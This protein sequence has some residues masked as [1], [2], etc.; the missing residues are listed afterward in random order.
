MHPGSAAAAPHRAPGRSCAGSRAARPRL[1][2]QPRELR[3]RVTPQPHRQRDHVGGAAPFQPVQE[4]QPPLRIRQWDLVRPRQRHQRRPRRL[5]FAHALRQALDGRRLE[6]AADRKLH[7]QGRADPADQPRR[8]Q[9]VAAEREEVVVDPDTLE[10]QHLRKQR[11]QHLLA[12]RARTA[13]APR[14]SDRAPAAH[15][16]RACRS[17]SAAAVPAPHRPKAPCS[18]AGSPPHA[19]AAQTHRA[20]ARRA[21][22]T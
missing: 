11:A 9:R 19:P 3:G 18:P 1:P 8:Q 14:G 22:T 16:G 20:S 5:A 2:A 15:A 21:A 13:H 10:P 17:A 6:Q 7:V 4:P 12:R